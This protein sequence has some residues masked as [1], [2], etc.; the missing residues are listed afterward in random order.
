MLL[1]VKAGKSY[2]CFCPFPTFSLIFPLMPFLNPVKTTYQ[3]GARPVACGCG[4]RSLNLCALLVCVRTSG[5]YRSVGALFLWI[6]AHGRR[7]VYVDIRVHTRVCSTSWA[8]RM[9]L[10]R[11]LEYAPPK[12]EIFCQPAFQQNFGFHLGRDKCHGPACFCLS[13]EDGR[14][15]EH[16]EKNLAALPDM[17]A[18]GRECE[19][20]ACTRW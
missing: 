2:L 3:F 18:N 12:G 14:E 17:C 5:R 20:V 19:R 6:C 9:C 11:V 1:K 15:E 13:F 10:L 7:L 16:C 8:Q 4:G